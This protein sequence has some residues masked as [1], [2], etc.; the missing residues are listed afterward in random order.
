MKVRRPRVDLDARGRIA[1][2]GNHHPVRVVLHD[3]ES[4]DG[5]GLRDLAGIVQF[6]QRQNLGY[7]AHVI[8]DKDANSA[9]CANGDRIC[10]HTS[11]RNTG[12]IGIEIIG[13]ARFS[14]SLW[15]ARPK[16]LHKVARWLAY[17]NFEYG[18]PLRASP[19]HGI[20]T[21]REQS[22]LYGGSHWDP[23]FF[24]PFNYVLRLARKYRKEGWR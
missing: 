12:S 11:R 19:Q 14:P 22:K 15:F 7:G 18:I 6:W 23:G 24:F 2:H 16:Q 8:V 4:H 21:H 17:Y 10:W 9:L 3:T 1:T 5:A 13:F 20:T